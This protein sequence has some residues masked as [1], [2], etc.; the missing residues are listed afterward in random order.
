MKTYL[1]TA[2]ALVAGAVTLFRAQTEADR[3]GR[4]NPSQFQKEQP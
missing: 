4:L 3:L 2:L 1:L